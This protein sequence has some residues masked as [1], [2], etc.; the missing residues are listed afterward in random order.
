MTTS[1]KHHFHFKKNKW[2]SAT[3]RGLAQRERAGPLTSRSVDQ[4]NHL[5]I[6]I[7]ILSKTFYNILL[8]KLLK[9]YSLL[10]IGQSTANTTFTLRKPKWLSASK[11][12]VAQRQRAGPITQRSQDRH[13]A[14]L[15]FI[16]NFVKYF[17]LFNE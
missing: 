6:L 14:L 8:K 15:T 4:N 13:L 3:N 7:I 11:S 2:L 10:Y 5:L 16:H 1:S 12:S 9:E 17:V